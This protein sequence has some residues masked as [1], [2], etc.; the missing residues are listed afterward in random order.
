MLI[1]YLMKINNIHKKKK[2]V[3]VLIIKK[4]FTNL[5]YVKFK[6]LILN[7]TINITCQLSNAVSASKNFGRSLV[8]IFAIDESK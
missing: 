8:C 6:Q 4:H 3:T 7:N 2:N 5:H 1:F